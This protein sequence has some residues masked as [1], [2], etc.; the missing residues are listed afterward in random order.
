MEEYNLLVSFLDNEIYTKEHLILVTK[1]I[2]RE[3]NKGSLQGFKE[4][5]KFNL[6]IKDN[7]MESYLFESSDELNE[8][9]F[10]KKPKDE[11]LEEIN[12]KISDAAYSIIGFGT[13]TKA[14]AFINGAKWVI[15]NLT[16]EE[17]DYLRING[18]KEDHSF[19]GF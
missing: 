7:E 13:T 6:N 9:F 1:D 2:W 10:D 12:L 3:K 4:W 8:G 19:F 17:I 5:I 15:N 14:G 11:K 18:N 16:Q